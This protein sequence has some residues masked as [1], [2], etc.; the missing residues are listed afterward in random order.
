MGAAL[1]TSRR[2]SAP[3]AAAL[4]T[5]S[6][7]RCVDAQHVGWQH[8]VGIEKPLDEL[9]R[10][11]EVAMAVLRTEPREVDSR[12][13]KQHGQHARLERLERDRHAAVSSGARLV[14]RPRERECDEPIDEAASTV[15][16]VFW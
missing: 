14:E 13:C 15:S 12:G 8:V 7:R 9:A 1:T 3:R 11:L 6:G 5:T 16:S 4:F 2:R 10:A